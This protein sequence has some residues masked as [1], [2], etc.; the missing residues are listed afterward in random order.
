MGK[1]DTRRRLRPSDGT[2]PSSEGR[3]TARK[4]SHREGR[5]GQLK[6]SPPRPPRREVKLRHEGHETTKE[7]N[8]QNY[9]SKTEEENTS[10][11]RPS[12]CS[13]ALGSS[14]R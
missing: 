12:P 8:I 5:E 1:G 3:K 11:R 13:S 9:N 10:A 2:K 7:R 4:K 14:N 6:R